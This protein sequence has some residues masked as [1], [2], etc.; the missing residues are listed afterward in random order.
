MNPL[1]QHQQK[2]IE[3]HLWERELELAPN[4]YLKV[5]GSIDPYINFME[6]GSLRIFVIDE[7]EEHTIRLPAKTIS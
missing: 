2:L 7:E 3:Q 4:E 1:H 6:E 5:K